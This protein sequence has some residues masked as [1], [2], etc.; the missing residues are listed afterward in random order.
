MARILFAWELGAGYGHIEQIYPIASRLRERGHELAYAM[1]DLTRAEKRA[2]SD[3]FVLM[4]APFFPGGTPNE[5]AAINYADVLLRCGYRD[6]E[7]LIG[8]VK[9]WL[10]L[11]DSVAPDLV[12][13]DHAPTALLA[14]HVGGRRAVAFGPG[15][16]V[17]PDAGPTPNM[18]PWRKVGDEALAAMDERAL[19]SLNAVADRFGAKPFGRVADLFRVEATVLATFAEL[20]HY[21][22]REGVTYVGPLF[23]TA[24]GETDPAWSESPS[25]RVFAYLTGTHREFAA[26]VGE[27]AR[28]GYPTLLHAREMPKGFEAKLANTRVRYA[29]EPVDMSWVVQHADVVA[30][31]GGHGTVATSLLGGVPLMLLPQH[32]EQAMM[33]HRLS[34]RGLAGALRQGQV[35]DFAARGA[36]QLVTDRRFAD[37]AK[38]V[39]AKYAGYDVATAAEAVADA[40]EAALKAKRKKKG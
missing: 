15:F 21:G 28:S 8:L 16:N 3:D 20:D 7:G 14:A 40:C 36:K 5:P 39:A 30:C 25:P 11:F 24:G 6:A 33:A 23:A 1:R 2:E 17:P 38:E 31:H 12:V 10:Y 13:V 32:L 18:Q 27:L 22:E 26:L 29:P 34:R 37:R 4:Q 19:A 35:K 9:G